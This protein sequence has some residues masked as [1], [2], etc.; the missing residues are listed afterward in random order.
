MSSFYGNIKFNNQT[1]LIFDK[2]YPSRKAMEEA[3]KTDGIFNGRYILVSYGE[4]QYTPYL[5]IEKIS[6]ETFDHNVASGIKY[7]MYDTRVEGNYAEV[8]NY[9]DNIT[10]YIK[11]DYTS[12]LDSTFAYN[13][14]QDEEKYHHDYHNTVWQKIWTSTQSEKHI[15][16]KYIMVSHLNAE[17]PTVRMIVDAPSDMMEFDESNKVYFLVGSD[18][19]S[20]NTDGKI[21]YQI[22]KDFHDKLYLED[23]FNPNNL[24]EKKYRKLTEDDTWNI[25]TIYFLRKSSS[26]Y[27]P[28]ADGRPYK[29]GMIS[30]GLYEDLINN[31]LQTLFVEVHE[32]IEDQTNLINHLIDEK[33][34]LK[35]VIEQ[36]IRS[37]E[38]QISDK[39][40]EKEDLDQVIANKIAENGNEDEINDL[41]AEVQKI[42]EDIAR[43]E[44]QLDN[45]KTKINKQIEQLE[46]EYHASETGKISEVENYLIVLKDQLKTFNSKYEQQINAKYYIPALKGSW[47]RLSRYYL[48]RYRT[49]EGRPHFDPIMS[50]DLEYRFHM[51]RNWKWDNDLDFDYNLEGFNPN[52][53]HFTDTKYNKIN[54]TN[55][56]SGDI[57]PLHRNDEPSAAVYEFKSIQQ[58]EEEI[59]D[60]KQIYDDFAS[61]YEAIKVAY[62][63]EQDQEEKIKLGISLEYKDFEV[64]Q[65]YT[66]WQNAISSL[67][68]CLKTRDNNC[69][70]KEKQPDTKRFNFDL[71]MLGDAV[72]NMWD[73]VYPKIDPS[74]HDSL[75]DVYIGNDRLRPENDQENYPE[76]LAESVRKLYY[77]LGLKDQDNNFKYGPWVDPKTGE[78]VDT[79]FGVLNGASDLLGDFDDAFS[80]QNF[81]PV[82]GPKYY[83][84]GFNKTIF[85]ENGNITKQLEEEEF[86]KLHNGGAGP[87]YIKQEDGS[88]RQAEEYDYNTQYYRNMNSLLSLLREWIEM[89]KDTQGDWIYEDNDE[90]Y[91][92]DN[93][94]NPRYIRNKPVVI[95]VDQSENPEEGSINWYWK[96]Y[97]L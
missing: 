65:A 87:L 46:E 20:L 17:T 8:T 16:E 59:R 23:G 97:A 81:Y 86:D 72:S 21:S 84:D 54:L 74:S 47:D 89:V 31:R 32:A 12:D 24:N 75:R 36:P 45:E 35:E 82:A 78:E 64:K 1:P 4:E 88:F 15:E 91:T 30:F 49:T 66:L 6:Q 77:Y 5:K 22:F 96:Y 37:L 61:E 94:L 3:C 85:D 93:P 79:I 52:K 71:K 13:K 53:A 69:I 73:K 41:R 27:H 62:E 95:T 56:A 92:E 60:A 28:Y 2:I 25:D 11:T 10:L 42:N 34:S 76:T 14:G 26:V 43:L 7:Y 19:F 83:P 9:N 48:M 90:D 67:N 80:D 40:S 18:Q 63:T 38:K 68:L 50:T 58:Q 44:Q 51:P 57:Y 29:D 39:R 33:N 55:K 70:I